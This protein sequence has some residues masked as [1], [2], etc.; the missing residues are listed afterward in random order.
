MRTLLSNLKISLFFL[1]P[2]GIFLVSAGIVLAIFSKSDIHLA[3]N[4]QHSSFGDAIMPWVTWGGEGLTIT[5]LVLLMFAWNRK[6][7]LLTGISCLFASG[8]TQLLKN[9]FFSG[10]P[11][12]KLFFSTPSPL[13]F[14]PGVENF[15]YDS[16]PSG[17]T[18]VAFAFYFCLVFA[19][20]NNLLKLSLF[21]IALLVGYSRIYMSQHFLG[22]V[23]AGSIIGTTSTL[24]IFTIA[25]HK[26]WLNLKNLSAQNEA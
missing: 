16:F 20:K 5:V 13:H 14:V 4:K 15:L 25:I 2:Q 21:V 17:H 22:D 18:T 7:A 11:R 24:L 8:I 10:E 19:V 6:F 23:F 12:P 26:G 9:T 3:I 1:I